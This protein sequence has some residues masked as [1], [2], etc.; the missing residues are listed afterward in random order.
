MSEL[1]PGS[2]WY[3][4]ETRC[5]YQ[6]VDEPGGFG[7]E[8]VPATIVASPWRA[9]GRYRRCPLKG[10]RVYLRRDDFGGRL[11]PAEADGG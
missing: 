6:L 11:I 7:P 4:A 8:L 5:T 1:A 3:A 2:L 9:R 10:D